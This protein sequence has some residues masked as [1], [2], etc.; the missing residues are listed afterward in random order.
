MIGQRFNNLIIVEE[1]YKNVF[2]CICDCG[3]R[4]AFY[5]SALLKR[6]NKTCIKCNKSSRTHGNYSHP[7]YACWWSMKQRCYSQNSM[8]YR[9]Y[10]GR[11][12]KVCDRWLN[13]FESF[14]SDMGPRPKG[15]EIDRIDSY[16]DY[17]PGNC[18]WV[19]Q[20]I[21]SINKRHPNK[22]LIF[23]QLCI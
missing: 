9:Y 1:I 19:T 3:V 16:G 7:L 14:I 18:R 4:H 23:K 11:G 2:E 6:K 10:G 20:K 15:Y 21:N 17:E 12:I 22:R 5:K 13:S 8:S